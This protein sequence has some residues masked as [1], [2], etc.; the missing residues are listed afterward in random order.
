MT[1]HLATQF[2]AGATDADGGTSIPG[3]CHGPPLSSI[4]VAAARAD[5][6]VGARSSCPRPRRRNRSSCPRAAAARELYSH[7][8]RPGPLSSRIE[9]DSDPCACG[10]SRAG[11][12]A[13]H[14]RGTA[15]LA[16]AAMRFATP[17]APRFAPARDTIKNCGHNLFRACSLV[18]NLIRVYLPAGGPPPPCSPRTRSPLGGSEQLP[19]REGP[20][21]LHS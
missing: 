12:A 13:R 20:A 16:P 3:P 5:L 14:A 15:L 10:A 17:L 4:S 9:K 2:M 19:W 21:C 6:I 8:W 11:G 7:R 18:L 1:E